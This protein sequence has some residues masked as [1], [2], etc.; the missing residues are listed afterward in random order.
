MHEHVWVPSM[1]NGGSFY[2]HYNLAAPFLNFY[3][4]MY[5]TFVVNFHVFI[6]A[7]FLALVKISH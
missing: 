1:V 2:G 6:Y 7:C 5:T 4:L 3:T